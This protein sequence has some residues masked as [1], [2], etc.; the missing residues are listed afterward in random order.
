MSEDC[1]HPYVTLKLSK[2]ITID[3]SHI[4]VEVFEVCDIC[5]EEVDR[6]ITSYHDDW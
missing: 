5:G 2:V 4:E 6:Y 3:R 1:F